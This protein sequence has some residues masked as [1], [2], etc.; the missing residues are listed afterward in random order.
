M[1]AKGEWT[2]YTLNSILL[3][4]NLEMSKA[5]KEVKFK[6]SHSR[7]LLPVLLW[8]LG[9]H[10][11]SD[12]VSLICLP[13]LS[14]AQCLRAG[15]FWGGEQGLRRQWDFCQR[16]RLALRSPGRT[17][18]LATRSPG[19]TDCLA[20]RSPGGTEIWYNMSDIWSFQQQLSAVCAKYRPIAC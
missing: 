7:L 19:R 18:W 9:W 11:I 16:P 12:S 15:C 14:S 8:Q 2:K 4:S 6:P 5:S 3:N 10:L 17:D 1:L 20:L 13:F